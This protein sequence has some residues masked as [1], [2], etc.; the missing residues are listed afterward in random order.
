MK[1]LKFGGSS[2]ADFACLQRVASLAKG[3]L[4][5]EILI[6]LSAPGGMTDS[7]V[8]L[9]QLAESGKSYELAWQALEARCNDLKE[10]VSQIASVEYWPD[11]SNLKQKLDGVAL[12]QQCPDSVRAFVISF[13]ERVSVSLMHAL[14]NEFSPV[15]LEATKCIASDNQFLDAQVDLT[16]S[17]KQFR[18]Q[19]SSQQSRVYIMPGFT[20]A[21]LQ[22]ELTTLGRNGSDYSAAI[23][24]ACL[25]AEVC[26]IW[27]DVDGVYSADPRFI[28][29]AT[30]V[31]QLSYKEAM[32]LSYFGAKVLHPKTILP[33][34]K[35]KCAMR[36]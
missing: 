10:Q 13:G 5:D 35:E 20:A 36:D 24:A 30:K 17:E 8:E 15:Y 12:L 4:E 7:L 16:V 2:L 3:Q 14:L 32:E 25:N 18:Q 28:K 23:A 31:D 33:C 19:V 26:Q 27:T 1:V 22:G 29:S 21:S 6:V 11:F 9:T 34:A